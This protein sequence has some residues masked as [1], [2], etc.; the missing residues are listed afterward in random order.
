MFC[1][2]QFK[3]AAEKRI[4]T[5]NRKKEK[6]R[7]RKLKCYTKNKTNYNIT[8]KRNENPKKL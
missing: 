5:A 4:I 2:M 8:K 1:K 6:E 7:E 3:S